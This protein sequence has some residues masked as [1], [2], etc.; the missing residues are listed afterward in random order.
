MDSET[1]L[2]EKDGLKFIKVKNHNYKLAFT[3]E[4]N[5]IQLS[6]IIDFNLIK[7]MYDLNGD[8]YEYVNLEKINENE[9]IVTLLIKH[10][11]E[12]LGLPQRFSHLHMQKIVDN[13]KI[14]FKAQSI[15][16]YKPENIPEQAELFSIIEVINTCN[17]MTDHAIAFNFNILFNPDINIPPFAEKM[18]GIIINKIFKR[19]KQFIENVRM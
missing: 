11:F 4:N 12:D 14:I 7:L 2:F 15:L 17:I 6:K 9:A 5:H 13:N 8:I 16:S 18:V 19:V 1:I 10:F 3:M